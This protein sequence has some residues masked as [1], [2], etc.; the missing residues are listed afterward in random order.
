MALIVSAASGNFNAGA[1]WV[2]GVVPTVGDTAQAST[3]H[4]ITITA[5]VTCDQIQNTSGS[6]GTFILN[7]GITLTA[8]VF[9]QGTA[10]T[11][12][13]TYSSSSNSSIVGNITGGGGTSRVGVRNSGSG[14]LNITGNV[15]GNPNGAWGVENT[16]T[17][18][19][20]I[21]GNC[22]AIRN[23]STGTIYVT[24][25][26]IAGGSVSG[27][28]NQS[29]G[30]LSVI[31]SIIPSQG[32]SGVAGTSFQQITILSGP[33]LTENVRGAAPVYCAAW[34][35]NAS[36]SNSTYMEVMTNNLLAK[37]N[38]VT[39]DNVTGMPAVTNV[40]SG[41]VY[42]PTSSLTGTLV[43]P[44]ANSVSFGVPVDNTT[45]TA[46]LTGAAVEAAVWGAATRTITGGT[47]DTLTNAPSVPSASAIASQVRTELS[48]ELG[49]VD[50][51][52]STRATP[53]NIPTADIT[54]IK[55]KTDL[56]NTTRLAQVST[57][58]IVGN[59]LAQANS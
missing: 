31:G 4:T 51:A 16:S 54:A 57:T 33:F 55:G 6:T 24:G 8:N 22:T 38:L 12:V 13:L 37:R 2:G 5:N 44:S 46:I 43:V 7:S 26:V 42:G 35:W 47:V 58:E 36:P 21:T 32:A 56:L 48:V 18:S 27:A 9:N 53:A 10:S 15:T 23:S 30:I 14:T 45:G 40:R 28:E 11:V 25:N 50:A 29:T 17:G 39:D 20:N 41:T 52:I 34:R 49:R 19:V 59:L 1:T 3:G